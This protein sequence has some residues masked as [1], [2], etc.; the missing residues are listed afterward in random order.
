MHNSTDLH[1]KHICLMLEA[2]GFNELAISFIPHCDN[3]RRTAT[4]V[5]RSQTMEKEKVSW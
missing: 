4:I 1:L 5:I 3:V 2:D